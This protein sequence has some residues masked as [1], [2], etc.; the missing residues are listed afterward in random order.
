MNTNT[1]FDKKTKLLIHVPGGGFQLE[2]EMLI[3]R[4]TNSRNLTLILPSDSTKQPWM[5]SYHIE[6]ITP[7]GTRANNKPLH[8]LSCIFKNLFQSIKILKKT[9]PECLICI[10]SS[11][12]IPSFAIAK[13]AKIPRIF[14][15][16]IT[17]T[18]T[19]SETGKIIQKYKLSSRFYVQWP[20]QSREKDGLLY[21]GTVL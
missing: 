18:D 6:T 15:E 20:E 19:L 12:C 7:L 13:M 8:V 14:I 5:D 3:N 17:R 9:Q 16:S 21:R 10:G 1:Y 4:L 2:T 11:I